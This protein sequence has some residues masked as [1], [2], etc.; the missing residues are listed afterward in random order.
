MNMAQF[1]FA[2]I[3]GL[4]LGLVYYKTNNIFSVMI[5]HIIQN[6]FATVMT[7]SMERICYEDK[8]LYDL[9]GLPTVVVLL[10]VFASGSI[11]LLKRLCSQFP[12]PQFVE[13]VE[14]DEQVMEEC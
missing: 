11:Y 8:H 5:I 4:I 7:L 6:T 1:V 13:N 12:Q 10:I 14:A 3:G 2:G 9:I